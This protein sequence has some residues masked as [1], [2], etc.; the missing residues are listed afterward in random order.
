MNKK[1]ALG[2]LA[3][4]VLLTGCDSAEER[5]IN[6]V[7]KEV[8]S[9]LLDPD[10]GRFTNM[11]A[12]QLGDNSH[13]YMVCGEVNGKNAL[14]AYTGATEF[15]AYIFDIRER[16]PITIVA[17]N[18]RTSSLKERLLFERQSLACIDNGVKRYLEK[19]DEFRRASEKRDDLK[20]TPLGKAVFD[21]ASDS[22]YVS[23]ELGEPKR[24][25]EVY[26]R[27]DDKHAFVSV[28][29]YDTPDFYKFRK[30]DKGELEPVKGLSYTGYPAAV[31]Q[32]QFEQV[33]SENCITEE[34]IKLLRNEKYKLDDFVVPP[35]E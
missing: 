27:E 13:S 1:N 17:M 30:S 33:D 11:R 19:E 34:E 25:R 31:K 35:E 14:N 18:N 3:A 23:R 12:L 4:S 10:S 20:K 5:A 15:N 9:T 2:L 16:E 26:A 28:T 22:S 29:N 7:E 8:R 32:C 24:I 6:L 21:A